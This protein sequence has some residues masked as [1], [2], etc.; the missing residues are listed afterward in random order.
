MRKSFVT[1]ISVFMI[2]FVI[3]LIII[4]RQISDISTLPDIKP[5]AAE[6]NSKPVIYFGVISRYSPNLIYNGYQPI[7]DYLSSVTPYRFELR[8]S[9]NY[10]QTIE[11][12]SNGRVA[13]A[14]L[15]AYVY[16]KFR[17]HH[18]LR[19]I[20]KPLNSQD[21]PYFHSVL[22]S[23][24]ESPVSVPQQLSGKRVALP[25]ELSFSANWFSKILLTSHGLTQN[26][27]S[28]I[29]YFN[30]HNTVIYQLLNHTFNA[31]VVKDRVAQEFLSSGLRILA[32]S[33]PVPASPIVICDKTP[34][35]IQK[36]IT[37]ALLKIDLKTPGYKHLVQNWD[38]EFQ[39]GFV[40]AKDADY[41]VVLQMLSEKGRQP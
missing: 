9:R 25:S 6:G 31:G 17:R 33:Q 14:F 28:E 18:H 4:Y 35:A 10:A 37:S 12:L 40:P 19:C 30:H 41:D 29:H 39:H 34:P 3:A 23:T 21:Q 32:Q 36:A 13:A 26:K 24:K 15:G 22:I 11:Q 2:F 1:A 7:M 38:A 20:L 5:A 27:L 16:V 8:L